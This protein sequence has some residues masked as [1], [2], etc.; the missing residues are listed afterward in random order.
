MVHLTQRIKES[1]TYLRRAV[2]KTPKTGI[3]QN[4]NKEV[5][6][7]TNTYERRDYVAV[8]DCCQFSNTFKNIHSKLIPS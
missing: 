1:L 4:L 2:A 5:I 3:L 6:D 7:K 8:A